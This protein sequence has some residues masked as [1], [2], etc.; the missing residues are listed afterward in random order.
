[1]A[2]QLVREIEQLLPCEHVIKI[3]MRRKHARDNRRAAAA[4]PAFERNGVMNF[5]R[6]MRRCL[7]QLMAGI[8]K[9]LQNEMIFEARDFTRAF[10]RRGKNARAVGIAMK[11]DVQ[12]KFYR[13]TERIETRAEV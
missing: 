6:N 9:C 8:M 11:R 2:F 3:S 5:E 12:I 4:Q 7:L 10:A 1:M 13:Q